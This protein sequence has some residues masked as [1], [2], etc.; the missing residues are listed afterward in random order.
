ME[1]R[2][3]DIYREKACSMTR[4]PLAV[5]TMLV[6]TLL[7]GAPLVAAQTDTPAARAVT[8]PPVSLILPN[9]NNV[10]VGE[11][12]ALEGGAFVARANDTSSGFYN[13][14]GLARADQTSVSGSAGAYQ[15][16]SVSPEG[17]DNV[18]GSL[19]QIPSMFAV[20]VNDLLGRPKWAGGFSITRAAA[21]NQ[22]VD[23]E[24]VRSSGSGLNRF[25]FSTDATYDAWLASV[26][27]GYARSDR[28]RL[29]GSLDG[30]YTAVSRRQSLDDQLLTA[31]GL[32]AVSLSS[33]G[34]VSSTH[35]RATLGAQYHV[36]PGVHLGAVMRTPGLG[37]TAS[38]DASLEGL[39][40]ARPATVASGF[41]DPDVSAEY[42]L[43]LEF[44]AG[45]AWIGDR[46]EAELD[47][48]TYSGTGDYTAI[49]SA[50][51]ITVAVDN[52][53]GGPPV[54]TQLTYQGARVDSRA[55]VNLAIGGRYQ[56]TSNRAWTLH[57][58]FATDGSPV[59]DQD[60]AFTKVNLRH[61]TVGLS[62]RTK[63]FLGSL[64]LRYS[65]GKSGAVTL[66][67]R[68]DGSEVSTIFKV[69]SMGLVYSVALLF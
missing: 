64:G 17:L 16:G 60:T 46:A 2:P 37:M 41:F 31:S 7:T 4:S 22:I 51:P 1:A 44:K 63:L 48:L 26:G 38:G 24:L 29:G 21:W 69:S 49:E 66:G 56:L 40:R 55:V 5:P 42:K 28:L 58:G 52:G 39:V 62:A 68:A 9:Y 6:F 45:V 53:Q 20:L 11:V 65:R 19:Q 8:V 27:V 43:P 3:L 34:G 13:P 61:L 33:A 57:A 47:V 23:T 50:A 59:G 10:P 32:S 30:Q 36:T 25:R 14:A 18:E 35:L 67:R 15:F 12:A 54:V